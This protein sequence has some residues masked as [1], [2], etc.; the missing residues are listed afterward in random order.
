[1]EKN[2]YFSVVDAFLFQSTPIVFLQGTKGLQKVQG[3]SFLK[4]RLL[5][6]NP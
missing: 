1:M 3:A 2:V 6:E 4:R 5:P